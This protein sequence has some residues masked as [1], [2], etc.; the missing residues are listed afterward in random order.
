V[1]RPHEI[2]Y[3]DYVNA[4]YERVRDV[5]ERDALA[6]CRAATKTSAA[7]AASLAAALRINVAGFEVGTDI[8]IVVTG[9]QETAAAPT[10]PRTAVLGIEWKAATLPRLFPF[11][12]A[13]LAIYPLAPTETQL[14]FHGWYEPPLGAVGGAL[15][16]LVGRRIA[17]A[18]VHRFVAEV[19]AYLRA[20]LATRPA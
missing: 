19:A 14:D 10:S 4:S 13:E 16:A 15:D 5:L 9:M 1:K 20:T 7:R 12:R 3:F 11:M 2:R 6:I 17:D 18:A 8:T